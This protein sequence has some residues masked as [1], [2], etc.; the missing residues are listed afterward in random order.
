MTVSAPTIDLYRMPN[1]EDSNEMYCFTD[2]R[3]CFHV[4]LKKEKHKYTIFITWINRYQKITCDDKNKE[5]DVC[6]TKNN[7]S[8]KKFK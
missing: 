5:E 7:S 4:T 2:I 8:S 3:I 1:V 6:L